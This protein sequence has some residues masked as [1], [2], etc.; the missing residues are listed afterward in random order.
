M[1]QQ[2]TFPMQ[3]MDVVLSADRHQSPV[4]L[5]S[6]DLVHIALHLTHCQLSGRSHHHISPSLA[7]FFTVAT[8]ILFLSTSLGMTPEDVARMCC[9]DGR[10]LAR[11]P[12]QLTEQV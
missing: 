8:R 2:T 10:L 4:V 6:H 11:R 9:K 5:A 7:S 3:S 12:E 1:V